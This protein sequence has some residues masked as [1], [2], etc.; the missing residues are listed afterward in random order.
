MPFSNGL[1]HSIS[2]SSLKIMDKKVIKRN[3]AAEEG[4]DNDPGLRD[5]SGQ[6]PG[7]STY[8]DRNEDH[9]NE[10]LT[11]TSGDHFDDSNFGHDA[12]P[13]FD[14]KAKKD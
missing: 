10:E 4:Q 9:K 11:K 3:R 5:R 6:Q 12:D 7:V 8:S 1:W 2:P 13:T 14:E